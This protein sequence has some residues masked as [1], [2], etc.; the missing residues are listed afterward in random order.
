MDVPMSLS[1]ASP[2]RT[3][4]IPPPVEILGVLPTLQPSGGHA[5]S[6]WLCGCRLSHPSQVCWWEALPA[7]HLGPGAVLEGWR[8][9]G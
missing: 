4:T 8:T 5:W 7:P 2:P 9:A 1:S 3:S 6:R